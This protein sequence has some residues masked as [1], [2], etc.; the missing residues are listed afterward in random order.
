MARKTKTKRKKVLH[1][2]KPR[3]GVARKYNRQEPIGIGYNYSG[4]NLLHQANRLTHLAD[5]AEQLKKFTG[6]PEELK[7]ARARQD[8]QNKQLRDRQ[9]ELQSVVDRQNDTQTGLYNRQ[10][11][12]LRDFQDYVH[13]RIEPDLHQRFK[14]QQKEFES[15]YK[16][17][18][19]AHKERVDTLT[20]KVDSL[21]NKGIEDQAGR[22]LAATKGFDVGASAEKRHGK[23]KEEFERNRP[24][25]DVAASAAMESRDKVATP[26]SSRAT[27]APPDTP[28][29]PSLMP[30]V[31]AKTPTV[32]GAVSKPDSPPLKQP[33][34]D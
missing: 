12:E 1:Y 23:F 11:K 18:S 19:D 9:D 16:K 22:F 10:N 4:F 25:L 7:A 26:G 31:Y 6:K 30:P 20:A 32:S 8:N 2:R 17:Q 28:A 29:V 34:F 15:K 13:Q 24:A 14:E 27:S 21:E 33:N 5:Q 3:R